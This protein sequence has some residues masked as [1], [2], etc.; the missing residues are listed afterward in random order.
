MFNVFVFG[1]Y[2]FS[3]SF[4]S[5]PRSRRPAMLAGLVNLDG[6]FPSPFPSPFFFFRSRPNSVAYNTTRIAFFPSPLFFLSAL[7]EKS[8]RRIHDRPPLFPFPFFFSASPRNY[9]NRLFFFPPRDLEQLH[10]LFH[11]RRETPAGV[12]VDLSFPG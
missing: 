12:G 7:V 9:A 6:S 1:L 5:P 11:I 2:H 10:S 8:P 3:F 4:F